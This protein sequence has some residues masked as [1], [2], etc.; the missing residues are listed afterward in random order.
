MQEARTPSSIVPVL[1]AVL[2]CDTAVADP[3]TG[4]KTLIGVFDRINVGRFPTQHPM[5]VYVKLTDAEGYYRV[6]IKFVQVSTGRALASADGE[7]QAKDRL[8]STDVHIGFPPL[9]IPEA[10]RYEFQ[11]WA[12]STYLGGT[13]ID[14]VPRST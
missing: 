9:P 10:G 6:N 1:I 3:N 14:A 5:S 8:L 11:V 13:S 4:K 12:N 7:L 2:V